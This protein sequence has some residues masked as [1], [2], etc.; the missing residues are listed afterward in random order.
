MEILDPSPEA[1]EKKYAFK[2]RGQYSAVQQQCSIAEYMDCGTV[3]CKT[4]AAHQAT[5][6]SAV[7]SARQA[8]EESA[9]VT[10]A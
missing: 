5:R 10:D 4:A 7:H 9:A 3:Q 8:A 1:Q 6:Y 2:V